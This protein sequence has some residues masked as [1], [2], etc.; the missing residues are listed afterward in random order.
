MTRT[1]A[2]TAATSA[3]AGTAA[4]PRSGQELVPRRSAVLAFA[5]LAPPV[6]AIGM[7]LLDVTAVTAVLVLV[8]LVVAAAASGLRAAGVVAALAAGLS[9]D[10]FLVEPVL[11][12]TIAE[13][14]EVEGTVLLLLTGLAVSEIALWGRRQQARAS[15]RSGYLDGVLR[16]ADVVA[17]RPAD[18]GLLA[19]Q[20]ADQVRELLG[21][22]DCRYEPARTV[23][24]RRPSA[25]ATVLERDGSVTR[26]GAVIDVDR[27]GL[28]TD[29]LVQLEVSGGGTVHG[30]FLV[31]AATRV[32]RPSV[33]QRRVAALLADQVGAAFA[34]GAP[35]AVAPPP[36]GR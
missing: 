33:E 15:R 3:T 27:Q 6:A 14:E 11:S 9:F 5:V 12:F 1:T 8:L 19:V 36:A 23:P 34:P 32:V 35:P 24:G 26:R 13:P 21:A 7:H 4:T 17:A 10:F 29:D 16:T 28:P 25:S 31:S 20:V 30:R 22:D 18:P 2:G